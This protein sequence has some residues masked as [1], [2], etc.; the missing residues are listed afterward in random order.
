MPRRVITVGSILQPKDHSVLQPGSSLGAESRQP[1]SSAGQ[2]S[3]LEAFTE[4]VKV[5]EHA[6][7]VGAGRCVRLLALPIDGVLDVVKACSMR[8][9]LD[10]KFHF[11]K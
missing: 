9:N 8:S 7:K 4:A 2:T 11:T 5:L 10:S 1:D 3:E 6:K